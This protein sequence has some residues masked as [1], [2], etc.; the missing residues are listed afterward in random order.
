MPTPVHFRGAG[1][2]IS[3]PLGPG[4][5]GHMR[6]VAQFDVGAKLR[7]QLS[8]ALAGLYRRACLNLQR[9]PG[10]PNQVRAMKQA[11]SLRS[12]AAG[13]YPKCTKIPSRSCAV[14]I[15]PIRCCTYLPER[16]PWAALPAALHFVAAVLPLHPGIRRPGKRQ[17]GLGGAKKPGARER[18]G[19]RP[20]H[21]CPDV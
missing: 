21:M 12:K 1:C 17:P 4:M 2:A 18:P 20:L 15:L 14:S 7:P 19:L 8:C 13:T 6:F 16:G 10:S 3:T 5:C 9:N 11:D